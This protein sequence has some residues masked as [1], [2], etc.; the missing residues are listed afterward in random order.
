VI[1]GRQAATKKLGDDELVQRARER[2]EAAGPD[3]NDL[4]LP[5]YPKR[6]LAVHW[7]MVLS[8]F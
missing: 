7:I 2:D 5:D 8:R 1:P 3:E 6:T 4:R